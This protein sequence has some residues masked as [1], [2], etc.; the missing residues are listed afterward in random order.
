M[1]LLMSSKIVER[2]MRKVKRPD[3]GDGCWEWQG[4]RSVKGYGQTRVMLAKWESWQS[5]R[6][7]YY[8]FY[9]VHPGALCVCHSCDNRACVNPAHL[10]L[11]TNADNVRDRQLK[12][13]HFKK[14]DTD[15]IPRVLE[16][17][18]LGATLLQI[19]AEFGVAFQTISDLL[20]DKKKRIERE[21]GDQAA[22]FARSMAGDQR[23]RND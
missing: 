13:R 1:L 12:Q 19:A 10:W 21:L 20:R 18:R 5:H 4:R 17:R 23:R 8:L 9:G 16:M 14:I 22:A 3:A 7:A 11:G 15:D 2:F 6:L